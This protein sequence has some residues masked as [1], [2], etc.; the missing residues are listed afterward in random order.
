MPYYD[1]R[2]PHCE[3]EYVINAT[4]TEKTEKTIACPDCKS[5]DLKTVFKAAPYF[6][7]NDQVFDN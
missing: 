3:K 4:I 6:K 2:C 5:T 7:N 1:L